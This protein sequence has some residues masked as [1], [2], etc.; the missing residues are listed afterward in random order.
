MDG[1]VDFGILTE[2]IVKCFLAVV[3]HL[4]FGR[5]RLHESCDSLVMG[6]SAECESEGEEDPDLQ[7]LHRSISFGQN[8]YGN[9]GLEN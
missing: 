6:K 9:W 1:R 5:Q 2:G 8:T 4:P 3:E 7:W